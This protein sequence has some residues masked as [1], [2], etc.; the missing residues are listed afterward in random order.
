MFKDFYL[1]VKEKLL[2]LVII[3]GVFF[4]F[5]YFYYENFDVNL[6]EDVFLECFN[7]LL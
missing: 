5:Y 3:L 7:E 6:Y 2:W 1:Y 4:G